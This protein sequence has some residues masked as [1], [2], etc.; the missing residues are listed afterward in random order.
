[1]GKPIDN[2][3]KYELGQ[4][5]VLKSE[6]SSYN[7][8]GQDKYLGQVMTIKAIA[9][10]T[11]YDMVIKV[12]YEFNEDEQYI[13]DY[14][15]ID[16]E[17][18]RELREDENETMNITDG[19]EIGDLIEGVEYGYDHGGCIIDGYKV[20]K[21]KLLVYA[22]GKWQ[23]SQ[24]RYNEL[25]N[26]KFVESEF[27]PK[28]GDDYYYPSFSRNGGYDEREW[29]D[30]GFDHRVRSNV[31]VFRTIRQAQEVSLQNGWIDKHEIIKEEI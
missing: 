3:T 31:G 30:D 20:E 16:H 2:F 25:I 18:T 26:M 10:S 14:D 7:W 23:E 13:W 17:K 9:T 27:N 1:M 6:V 5:V 29:C 12:S 4:K 22:F 24:L 8:K 21:G 19:F 15:D 11:T 28:V